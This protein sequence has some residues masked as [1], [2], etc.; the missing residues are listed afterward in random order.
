MKQTQDIKGITRYTFTNRETN[1][2]ISGVFMFECEEDGIFI[3]TDDCPADAGCIGGA[4]FGIHP[5][6]LIDGTWT[7]T[8]H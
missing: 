3:R 5:Y 7:Y 4:N 6:G 8:R 2:V 1:E